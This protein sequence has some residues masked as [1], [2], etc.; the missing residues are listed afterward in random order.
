LEEHPVLNRE[1]AGSSPAGQ[2]EQ[3][4]GMQLAG[5]HSKS[6]VRKWKRERFKRRERTRHNNEERADPY[7]AS[8]TPGIQRP[9]IQHGG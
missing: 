4:A 6:K 5:K 3:E 2:H 7:A 9:Q 8:R 1:V